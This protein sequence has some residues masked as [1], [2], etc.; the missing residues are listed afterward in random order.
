MPPLALALTIALA[1][2]VVIGVVYWIQRNALYRGYKDVAD[3]ARQIARNTAGE[4]FRDNQDLLIAG[5]YSQRP[6]TVRFAESEGKSQFMVEM[7][8]P[9]SFSLSLLP[10]NESPERRQA[11]LRTGSYLL[12]SKFAVV[13]GQ[14]TQAKMILND[15]ASL[16]ALEKLCYS[17]QVEFRIEHGRLELKEAAVPS[18]AAAR[19]SESLQSLATIAQ[20]VEQIPGAEHIDIGP[21]HKK[22]VNWNFRALLIV[23]FVAIVYL[24]LARPG[25]APPTTPA[26]SASKTIPGV[27]P[28]D[29]GKIRQLEGWHLAAVDDFSD[30]AKQFLQDR[31]LEPSGRITADFS[32][33]GEQADNAYLL[34]DGHGKRRVSMLADRSLAFDEIFDHAALIAAIP[35]GRFTELKWSAAP[36][37]QPDGDLLLIVQD[38]DNPAANIVLFRNGNKIVSGALEDFTAVNFQQQ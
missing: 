14:P 32:G 29:A 3:D 35:K 27:D 16:T 9:V 10:R 28:L 15:K 21:I 36:A 12:D 31:S 23:G 33:K 13:T 24:L 19:T 7:R 1:L 30:G 20:L 34:A 5:S 18:S 38:T 26:Q 22:K 11:A 6:V 4:I 8:V 2:P 25:E 37:G 17:R